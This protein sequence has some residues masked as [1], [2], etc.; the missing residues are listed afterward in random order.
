M[1]LA[2]ALAL[3]SCSSTA[4]TMSARGFEADIV[5]GKRTINNAE[6]LSLQ[7]GILIAATD[8][9][10]IVK[11]KDV[12]SIY[13]HIDQH[14]GG[15][16]AMVG[17]F[18]VVPAIAFAAREDFRDGGAGTAIM[19]GAAGLTTIAYLASE[20]KQTYRWPLT[21]KEME[22]LR[23]RMRY[24]YGISPTQIE[25][26]RMSML[27]D[28]TSA[29]LFDSRQPAPASGLQT[30]VF[31]DS[32]SLTV[33]ILDEDSTRYTIREESGATHTIPKNVVVRH[34]PVGTVALPVGKE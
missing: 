9:L 2:A 17:I 3:A 25:Q 23:L 11:E 24:P 6:L 20:P 22:E 7:D 28:T 18:Q 31:A 26:L 33:T 4:R 10:W 8:S 16:M 30:M 14:R 34:G 13:L 29:P 1:T 15:W 12:E 32:T 21:P 5:L 19:L 27:H